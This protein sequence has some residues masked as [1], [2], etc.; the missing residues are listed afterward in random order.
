MKERFG[1]MV[2]LNKLSAA[3][4]P[5]EAADRAL[6]ESVT[7]TGDSVKGAHDAQFIIDGGKAYIVYE[8]NDIQAGEN[9]GWTFIYCAMSIVDVKTRAVEKI[10]K[11]SES[12]QAFNNETLQ[13]GATFVPRIV[14]KSEGVL[15]VFF[16]SERPGVRQSIM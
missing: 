10:I 14:K 8:C 5:Q 9:A 7:V 3:Y 6:L 11:I 13:E 15:R 12:G 1:N 2:L 16:S 4:S